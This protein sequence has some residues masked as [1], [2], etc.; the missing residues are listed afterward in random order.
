MH[1][2]RGNCTNEKCRYAHVRVN[3]AAPVCRAFARLGYCDKGAECA[4]RHVFECPDYANKGFCRNETCRLPHV[5]RAGQIRKSAAAES[6]SEPDAEKSP[7]LTSD[8]EDFDQIDSDDIDS[9]S[10][11]DVFLR[12]A[13]DT[14][15]HELSQQ[16]D[17]V[18]F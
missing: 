12:G 11:E 15:G 13:E 18:Q 3:P 14:R 4:D 10:L 9:D 5:D 17:Y 1:F 6:I 2:L 7:D 16:Q 8:E